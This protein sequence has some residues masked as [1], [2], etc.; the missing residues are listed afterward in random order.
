MR[1]L[2][3]RYGDDGVIY[4][5]PLEVQC[6]GPST[7][8]ESPTCHGAK[9]PGCWV[10]LRSG[11]PYGEVRMSAE[12]FAAAWRAALAEGAAPGRITADRVRAEQVL[13]DEGSA[14][15]EFLR[16]VDGCLRDAMGRAGTTEISM[17]V[18]S[19]LEAKAGRQ[20]VLDDLRARGFHAT[21]EAGHLIVGWKE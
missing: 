2:V 14:A 17:A 6:W 9:R 16:H 4:L 3:I 21:W 20:A 12:A 1:E 8:G 5:N 13:V 11:R 7:I 18:G 19:K 15:E 10:V